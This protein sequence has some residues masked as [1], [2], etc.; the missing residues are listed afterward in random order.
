MT[1]TQNLMTSM[2]PV[3]RFSRSRIGRPAGFEAAPTNHVG[4]DRTTDDSNHKP[5]GSRQQR[6]ARNRR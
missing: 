6:V 3:A 2:T 1:A 5:A 4:H